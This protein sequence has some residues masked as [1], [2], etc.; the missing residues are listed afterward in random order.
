[1]QINNKSCLIHKGKPLWDTGYLAKE[2]KPLN[3]KV[4]YDIGDV[5]GDLHKEC[6]GNIEFPQIMLRA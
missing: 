6:V 1:M 3:S 2:T 5:K 4:K